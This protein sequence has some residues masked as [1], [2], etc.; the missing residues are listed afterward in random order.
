[1][2]KEHVAARDRPVPA[3][4]CYPASPGAARELDAALLVNPFDVDT[5]AEAMNMALRMPLE[6]RRER[7]QAMMAAPRRNDITAWR[8]NFVASLARS[9]ALTV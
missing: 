9:G 7:Y 2:A 3:C 1:V 5:M 4:S 8:G 6:E